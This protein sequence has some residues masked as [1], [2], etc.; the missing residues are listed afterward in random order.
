MTHRRRARRI[1]R[2][3]PANA[4]SFG[5][6]AAISS[7]AEAEIE[8]ITGLSLRSVRSI[9]DAH[10]LHRDAA[11]AESAIA[12]LKKGTNYHIYLST[13]PSPIGDEARPPGSFTDRRESPDACWTELQSI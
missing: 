12:N 8:T 6:A 13:D 5:E 7:C 2:G 9:L 11:L 1:H 10:Y 4:A 3:R